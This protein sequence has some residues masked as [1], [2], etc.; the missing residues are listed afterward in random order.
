MMILFFRLNYVKINM[1][2]YQKELNHKGINKN[3][4]EINRFRN[5]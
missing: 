1:H 2:I 3:Y 4:L 5:S